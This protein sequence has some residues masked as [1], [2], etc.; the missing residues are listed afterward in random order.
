MSKIPLIVIQGPTAVGKSKLAVKLAKEI[1]SAI[2]S[3]D[4]RQVYKYLN[5][6]TAKPTAEEQASVEHHLIDIIEPD[7]VYSAGA[8]S[9]DAFRLI[10]D[11]SS[12][13]KI[14]VIC[15][16]T[17]FYISA[18]L[19]GIFKAPEIPEKIRHEIRNSIETKGVQHLFKRLQAIDPS[20][21]ERINENDANRIA[22]ALEIYE[23]SGRTIT[24]LWQENKQERRN[25]KTLNIMV[26]ED[27][28]T[29]YEKINLRV[30]RMFEKGLLD[31]METLIS[32]GY[33][34]KDPG[35]NTVGYKELFPYFDG[36]QELEECKAK[37]KKN[38]R[39]YAKR[40]FT[41]YRKIDFDL[42]LDS[43]SINFSGV[44]K[45]ISKLQ[46]I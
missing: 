2:I 25:F 27:R 16:G 34:S 11:L 24:E 29:L 5:I 4:S 43:K 13:N 6:G 18:L 28:K 37:I 23:A 32:K 8:F 21:A 42:T 19:D 15:G 10:N 3:A 12:R 38:T 7:Q 30:D 40:Q 44:L 14:P 1:G 36:K 33:N 35:L 39:N 20:S 46:E 22:R 31:E 45:E 26:D 41:W 17:G 9:D